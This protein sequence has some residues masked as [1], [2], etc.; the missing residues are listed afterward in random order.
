MEDIFEL[1]ELLMSRL[2]H[3][4]AGPVGAINNGVEL[5]KDPNPAFHTESINL[6]E[7][8]AKE[9]VARLL[10]FRQAYGHN[11]NQSG[12]S[13]GAIKDL[14][15]NFYIN[16]NLTFSWPEAH[17]DSDS[18]QLIKVEMVRL[19]LNM[20]LIVSFSLIH[21]GNITI[22]IKTNKN[23][24]GLKVRGEGKAA[25]VQEYIKKGLVS[26]SKETVMDSKN[27][28]AYL[29]NMLAIKIG[30]KLTLD[31][32]DSHFEILVS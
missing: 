9:A 23:D 10:Y 21:G 1:S 30:K 6:I 11:K 4:L 32:G 24:F 16:K 20:I 2:C 25:K 7:I 19:L 13:L 12:I 3:D 17:G 31:I 28:Q 15:K 22:K 8:S 26:D 18:M 14:V 27:V 29:T 5:L